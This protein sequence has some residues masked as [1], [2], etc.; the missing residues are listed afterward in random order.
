MLVLN[1]LPL[2]EAT[3]EVNDMDFNKPFEEPAS[4]FIHVN[5]WNIVPSVTL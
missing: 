5:S 2:F 3:L 4:V 1:R